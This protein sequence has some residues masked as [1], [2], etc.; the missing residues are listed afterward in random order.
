MTQLAE[1][2][3]AVNALNNLWPLLSGDE[4]NRV[5]EQRNELN[6]KADELAVKALLEGTT[7]IEQAVEQLNETTQAAIEAKDMIADDVASIEKV[8][9]TVAKATQAVSKLGEVLLR[10]S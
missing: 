1:L 9:D 4:K 5:L 6:I 8:S 7:E 2:N 10:L 3:A